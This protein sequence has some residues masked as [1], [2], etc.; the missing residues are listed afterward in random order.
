MFL[1]DNGI[2]MP[3]AKSN[4]YLTSADTPWLVRWPGQIK[5]GLVNTND[6]ILGIDFMPTILQAAGPRACGWPLLPAP[7]HQQPP[8]RSRPRLHLLQRYLR[9]QA[10][11]QKLPPNHY[12]RVLKRPLKASS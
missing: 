8:T 1:S 4:C 6:S 7:P 12:E 11:P 3:F 2:S 10:L 9:S 5:P